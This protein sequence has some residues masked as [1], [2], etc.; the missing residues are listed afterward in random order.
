MSTVPT[1]TA[2]ANPLLGVAPLIDLPWYRAR[3]GLQGSDGQLLRDWLNEPSCWRQPPSIY[4]D[5]AYYMTRYPDVAQNQ[6]NPLLHYVLHGE[7]EGRWPNR[8]FDP[9]YYS[10]RLGELGIDQVDGSYLAHYIA[11]G[12]RLG[13][14]PSRLFNAQAYLACN[15]DVGAAGLEPLAHYLEFGTA[16]GRSVRSG[17]A[18]PHA[19]ALQDTAGA[20]HLLASDNPARTWFPQA[21]FFTAGT[22][23]ARYRPWKKPIF[24]VIVPCYDSNLHYLKQCLSSVLMQSGPS[25]ELIVVD[26]GSR[27]RPNREFFGS[28][29]R[30]GVKVVLC[31]T[32]GGISSAS[33]AGAAQACGTW[34]VFLDHDDLLHPA[35]LET[36]HRHAQDDPQIDYMF[37]DAAKISANGDITSVHQKPGWDPTLLDTYMFAGQLLCI[38]R[39]LFGQLKG[40]DCRFDGCQDHDLALRVAETGCRVQHLAK[41]LYY[42]RAIPGSTALAAAEK[43]Y[44]HTAAKKAIAASLARRRITAKVRAASWAARSHANFFQ[45]EFPHSGPSVTLL[46]PTH[47]NVDM[48]AT[49]LTSIRR[50]TRYRQYNI[51]I[52]GDLDTSAAVKERIGKLGEPV[53]IGDFKDASGRFSFSKKVNAGV[54][55]ANDDYVLLL[56]DDT[57]VISPGWLSDMM[58]YAQMPG[59]GAIGAQLRYPDGSIQHAGIT[60]GLE[61]GRAGHVLKG[62]AAGHEGYLSYRSASRSVFGVTAACLLIAKATYLQAGG[63]DE[64][65][66]PLAYNDVDFCAKV[67][68]LGLRNI[69]AAQAVLIHHEG[70]TRNKG[71]RLAEMLRYRASYGKAIDPYWNQQW[72][73][74]QENIY[75]LH[76]IAAA[77]VIAGRQPL[78]V[79]HNSALQGATKVLCALASLLG[80]DAGRKPMMLVPEGPLGYSPIEQDFDLGRLDAVLASSDSAL[81]IAQ[82][83]MQAELILKQV[84]PA[85]VVCNTLLN[86]PVVIAAR[87]LSLVVVWVIHESEGVPFFD[88]YADIVA[89][90]FLPQAMV[91]ASRVVFVSNDCRAHYAQFDV[92][93]N[94]AVIRNGVQAARPELMTM[95]RTSL[96]KKHRVDQTEF[97][98]LTVGTL[99]ERKAQRRLA[100]LARY[101]EERD[102]CLN[103]R[104]LIVGPSSDDYQHLMQQDIATLG[105]YR[106]RF[107]FVGEI[108][109][110]G[111]YY[112]L[113][114]LFIFTSTCEA[115]P[116]V[117]TEALAHALPILSTPVEGAHDIVFHNDI[118][119]VAPFDQLGLWSDYI[120]RLQDSEIQQRYA[121]AALQ[122][123]AFL[124]QWDEV[125]DSYRRLL[126]LPPRLE[127]TAAPRE[128]ESATP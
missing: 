55:M 47:D 3:H 43:P 41:V 34:L 126:Q 106:D 19:L 90:Y 89:A 112:R 95:R 124:P 75:P 11:K 71:D 67:A 33:N 110:P 101:L 38:R 86:L 30:M 70:A 23:A 42:W 39:T 6:V 40:F 72:S 62:L 52:M 68:Q 15:A 57:E 80:A 88:A 50:K 91:S 76:N 17:Q 107:T 74:C 1:S 59:S 109:D 64:V 120:L 114:D 51:L 117:L 121:A 35:A 93:G 54:A 84:G 92:S 85:Y 7:R 105:H 37:S 16:E 118:G 22:A 25:M 18:A 27:K 26:D 36:L 8:L 102:I 122:A 28:L 58:G 63:F 29:E 73:A 20:M 127:V 81:Q 44:A 24:S 96:R 100:T 46:I 125:A 111:T 13:V 77:P 2:T 65:R 97:V 5:P 66:F 79:S 82:K 31:A 12:A 78:F 21:D 4:F 61:G 14:S 60:V 94:F 116:T 123:T 108:A 113:A 53:I 104:F 69:Y 98:I 9:V 87:R 99:C 115:Y 49:L 10:A 83:I 48:L 32:N 128:R 45:L 119:L 56:N 103:I